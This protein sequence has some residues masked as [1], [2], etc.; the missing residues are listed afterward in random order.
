MQLRCCCSGPVLYSVE[1][2]CHWV[3][4]WCASRFHLFV[5]GCLFTYVHAYLSKSEQAETTK[6]RYQ[7]RR[8]K[9][10]GCAGPFGQLFFSSSS[11]V[12][13]AESRAPF[14]QRSSTA[15][16]WWF[17]KVRV[18]KLPQLVPQMKWSPRAPDVE[19]PESGSSWPVELAG[20]PPQ[21][22]FCGQP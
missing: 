20:W 11:Q 15:P 1:N 12:A 7:E 14:R 19:E 2:I 17:R 3:A 10:N 18:H 8:K 6:R 5:R 16:G 22:K 9:H 13:L 21:N 4:A